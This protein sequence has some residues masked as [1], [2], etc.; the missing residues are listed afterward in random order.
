MAVISVRVEKSGRVLIPAAVRRKLGLLEG[1]S[2]LLLDIDERPI[3]V[4]TRA[5]AVADFQRWAA[6]Y[7]TP[8][9]LMSEELI[10]DR[11]SEASQEF[12]S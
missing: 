2:E 7:A 5:Q 11:R 8:G 9:R 3:K 12:A 4:S 1:K 10:E 6:Q